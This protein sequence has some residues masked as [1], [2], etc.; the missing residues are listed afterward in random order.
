MKIKNKIEKLIGCNLN[1]GVYK[2]TNK[3]NGK[4][5]VGESGNLRRRI[6]THFRNC[7]KAAAR[8][9][10]SI[11]P[12]SLFRVGLENVDIEVL[13]FSEYEYLRKMIECQFVEMYD[14]IG[15]SLNQRYSI[16]SYPSLAGRKL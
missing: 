4:V 12:V 1:K 11:G 7:S 9:D 13:V 6:A 2:I 10:P 5:Y 8:P 3:L 14:Y 15:D 16:L